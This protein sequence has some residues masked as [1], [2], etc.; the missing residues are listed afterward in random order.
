MP[1]KRLAVGWAMHTCLPQS[2]G[3]ALTHLLSTFPSNQK[4]FGTELDW[5]LACTS[6][7]DRYFSALSC[8]H[9]QTEFPQ[10]DIDQNLRHIYNLKP[11]SHGVWLG[12]PR[13]PTARGLANLS[14]AVLRFVN[15]RFTSI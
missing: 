5:A 15:H 2:K 6:H 9:V 4:E 1:E 14:A 12:K 7:L 3:V 11:C 13:V 8:S 10:T